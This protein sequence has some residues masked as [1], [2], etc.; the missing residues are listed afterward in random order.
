MKKNL[1]IVAIAGLASAA[2]A[3]PTFLN[4]NI[5]AENQTGGRGTSDAQAG[6]L[7]KW[8][9]SAEHDG[10]SFG[11]AKLDLLVSGASTGDVDLTE[12][13]GTT[14][15]AFGGTYTSGRTPLLVNVISDK[16]AGSSLAGNFEF[17][18]QD[19]AGTLYDGQADVVISDSTLGAT[20][21]FIDLVS[22]PPTQN[23]LVGI[24]PIASGDAVLIFFTTYQG[25]TQTIA[26]TVA[27]RGRVFSSAADG[28]GTLVTTG[29]GEASV[30]PAPASLALLGLGGLAAARRRRA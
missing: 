5:T 25:G 28:S 23:P 6:D 18:A 8:T 26:G 14:P 1:A 15:P 30:T 27:G 3:Q 21:G 4:L 13:S 12:N 29:A 10:L 9:V 24:A 11:G 17:S 7:I 20:S 22:F 19:A 2:V 16:P